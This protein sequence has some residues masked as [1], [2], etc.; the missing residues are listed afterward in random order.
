MKTLAFPKSHRL[1]TPRDYGKVFDDVQVRVPHRNFLILATPNSLGHARVGLVFS[2][3]NLK[4]AV[5]RNR[6]KRRVR[7]TFRLQPDLPGLDIIVLGRQGL[8]QLDN[9]TLTATLND[10]WSR[11][12]RKSRQSL[13]STATSPAGKGTD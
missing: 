10:L 12:I 9:Q 6:V 7:E 13:S 8:V 4:L 1:L 5:Q 3:K 2:K 11:L